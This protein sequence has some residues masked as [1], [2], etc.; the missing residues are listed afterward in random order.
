MRNTRPAFWIFVPLL[1]TLSIAAIWGT[2][3]FGPIGKPSQAAAECSDLRQFVAQEEVIGRAKWVDYRTL[4]DEFLALAPTD[5][6][7][8]PLIEEMAGTV[9]EILGHDLTIYKELEK[10]S[11]CVLQS[12]REEIPGMIEET[13]AAINFLNG[14]TPIDGNYF[15]PELG[16]WNTT[17]YEEFLSATDFL[18]PGPQ[19]DV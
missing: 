16:S 5:P 9:I 1:L 11:G 4:V 6:E 3:H 8:I 10:F 7:R 17:Y 19:A 14:S 2:A 12:R 15:D 13:E 18:K